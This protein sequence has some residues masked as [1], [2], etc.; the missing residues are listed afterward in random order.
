MV[1]KGAKGRNRGSRRG[2]VSVLEEAKRTRIQQQ[3]IVDVFKNA[4][5]TA[6]SSKTFTSTLQTVKQALFERDFARAFG[7]DEYLAVYAA[8][9]S[10]T[11][12]LC[13]A[14]VLNNIWEHLADICLPSPP[15]SST[16]L[17]ENTETQ[18][19]VLKILSFGGG[20]AELVAFAAFLNQ[21]Q[22]G[23]P[24][25]A[26]S[27]NNLDSAAWGP[28]I[29]LL[30]MT[31][32]TGSPS[33]PDPDP[34]TTEPPSPSTAAAA[35]P[36]IPASHLTSIF[37]LQ[38]ALTLSRSDLA[39]LLGPSPLLV[40][41]LFTLNELFSSSGLGKTTKFLLDL[42]AAVPIG[43]LL[44][45]VD[46]PGSYSETTLGKNAKKYPMQW[47][48]D[49]IVLTGTRADPVAG[50]R[51]D[52]LESDDSLWFRLADGL[53]YPIPLENMRYQMHLYQAEAAPAG[54]A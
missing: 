2:T 18:S 32:T 25:L 11:R 37:T 1:V 19:P 48:L 39:A 24:P 10:P 16:A 14:S 20:A 6:L 29:T 47:L 27:I 34:N 3:L 52:K 44:L 36:L 45:V 23:S 12:A 33:L 50:K 9:Y 49:R 41:L 8:R 7:E 54:K 5:S 46:S 15:A 30:E 53:D 42:T 22:H 28:V 4:F 43:S 51:W 13:Y 17:S 35:V 21:R 40:T 26:G 31:L 38:D